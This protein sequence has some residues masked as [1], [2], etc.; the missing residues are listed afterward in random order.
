MTINTELLECLREKDSTL[1]EFAHENIYRDSSIGKPILGK[2]ENIDNVTQEMVREF[3]SLNYT[4]E[5]FYFLVS[6]SLSH[7]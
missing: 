5:N 2:R 4:G 7:N 1:L 3:Y 6:S